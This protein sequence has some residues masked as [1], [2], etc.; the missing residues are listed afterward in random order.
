[1]CHR[2]IKPDNIMLSAN[3]RVV[4]VDFGL[5]KCQES[6]QTLTAQ[7]MVQGTLL[8]MSPESVEGIMDLDERVD[9]WSCGVVLHEMLNGKP[10]YEAKNVWELAGQI[11]IFTFKPCLVTLSSLNDGIK[12]NRVNEFMKKMLVVDRRL[13]FRNATQCLAALQD[14]LRDAEEADYFLCIKLMIS[15]LLPAVRQLFHSHWVQT[16][17]QPWMDCAEC[18][19]AYFELE[20]NKSR[21]PKWICDAVK[22]GDSGKW[23]LTILSNILLW[24]SVCPLQDESKDRQDLIKLRQWR[25]ELAH[26]K[27]GDV[28]DGGFEQC[29]CCIRSFISRHEHSSE[30]FQM[31]GKTN[32]GV[33]APDAMIFLPSIREHLSA[34]I[35]IE[36]ELISSELGGE[37][38]LEATGSTAINDQNGDTLQK[39]V[40]ERAEITGLLQAYAS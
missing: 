27:D 31:Q 40:N 3:E 35:S 23:D 1:M 4:L 22:A 39:L 11:K 12:R 28:L 26:W 9:V 21:W 25:N 15:D 38:S 2:D 6:S 24:S 34:H 14:I 33:A 16:C 13:R 36:K 37:F 7:N 18:G 32:T 30:L 10:I 19:Q 17:S 8:Y 29:A 5:S 20:A